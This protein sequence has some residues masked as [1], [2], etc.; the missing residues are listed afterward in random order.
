[1][2]LISPKTH[3]CVPK[4]LFHKLGTTIGEKIK[5]AIVTH[6]VCVWSGA[7]GYT[8]YKF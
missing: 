5:T 2:I 7:G 4:A 6:F 3:S 8:A 1:M